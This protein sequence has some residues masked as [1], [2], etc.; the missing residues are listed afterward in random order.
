MCKPVRPLFLYIISF[1]FSSLGLNSTSLAQ[2]KLSETKLYKQFIS[3]EKDTSRNSKFLV[4]PVLGYA[5]ETALEYGINGSL[6]FFA[7]K[8]DSSIRTSSINAYATGTT[9]GQVN[10]KAQADI[11]LTENRYHLIGEIRYR[12][13]PFSFYGI[14]SNTWN[15][16]KDP[17]I[18]R[19][20]RI[21]L[22]GEKEIRKYFYT[23]INIRY[24]HYGYED[25]EPGGIYDTRSYYGHQG[26]QYMAFGLS[27]SFDKRNSV[28][29]TTKGSFARIK[30]SY[31]P[32]FWGKDNF[33]GSKLELDLRQF[34][35]LSSRFTLGFNG[36]YQGILSKTVPFYLLPELGNDQMMRGYYQGRYRDKNMLALQ[37]EI[38]YRIHPRIGATAFGG[39][40]TVS[41]ALN[42]L[43]PL[44]PSFGAGI[45]YFFDLEH[46]TSVRIDYGFGEKRPGEKRQSGLYLSLGQ[47]F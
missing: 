38:R 8:K 35:P 5:Q 41:P 21:A 14:G 47:A 18:Q 40:G 7:D 30:I 1:L 39:L 16:D 45:A 46:E 34:F 32:D 13:Y 23:G 44:K 2:K 33:T 27:Q 37:T 29:Y 3:A 20:F 22:E 28:T 17:L 6:N 36:I 31:A 15:K 11:W 25:K 43:K 10:L 4:F 9:K 42:Q 24:E 26:G 12:H 19:L